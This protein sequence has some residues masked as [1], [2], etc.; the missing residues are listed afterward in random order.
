MSGNL[1]SELQDTQVH[2]LA[3]GEGITLD[4]RKGGFAKLTV[5][6]GTGATVTVGRVDSPDATSQTGAAADQ[7]DVAADSLEATNI[8]WPFWRVE[9]A[10]GPAR[11]ALI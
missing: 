10:G 11:V 3:A 5:I 2:D 1:A 7:F 4:A 8:D 9:T 6:A